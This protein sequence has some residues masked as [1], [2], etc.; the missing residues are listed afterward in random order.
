MRPDGRSEMSR[1]TKQLMPSGNV[2]T[3]TPA[4]EDPDKPGRW[5]WTVRMDCPV[6]EIERRYAKTL[7]TPECEGILWDPGPDGKKYMI[8]YHTLEGFD[9]MCD[10]ENCPCQGFSSI[11]EVGVI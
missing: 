6:T 3:I 8:G 1:T 9:I 2:I 10:P 11:L 7:E 5:T 4:M